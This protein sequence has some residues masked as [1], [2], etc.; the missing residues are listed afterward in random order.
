MKFQLQDRV[1]TAICRIAG[2]T[3][4][5]PVRKL[6]QSGEQRLVTNEL[7][8]QRSI[9][10]VQNH[11]IVTFWPKWVCWNEYPQ[12]IV[13]KWFRM[14]LWTSSRGQVELWSQ[15]II[16][17]EWCMGADSWVMIHSLWIPN[18]QNNSFNSFV[19]G[20]PG[21][22]IRL[23]LPFVMRS[24]YEAIIPWGDHFTRRHM[25]IAWNAIRTVPEAFQWKEF[26][27]P[28]GMWQLQRLPPKLGPG[29]LIT[30]ER[31][32]MNTIRWIEC[33][34]HFAKLN[35]QEIS[36]IFALI[37]M[38]S[39]QRFRLARNAQVEVPLWNFPIR[40]S[41]I[42]SSLWSFPISSKTRSPELNALNA[43]S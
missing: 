37:S 29:A 36:V 41:S 40:R 21:V 2:G 17:S 39:F 16:T 38:K 30:V 4:E 31:S 27:D 32:R 18:N 5:L 20:P 6:H 26:N 24:F 33:W 23:I 14:P 7:A 8:E 35:Y 1:L 43:E 11:L 19:N 42:R 22:S 3:K 28:R 13:L 25:W 15:L 10:T 34:H 9:W 12:M